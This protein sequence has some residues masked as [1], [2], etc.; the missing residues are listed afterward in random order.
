MS[1]TSFNDRPHFLQQPSNVGIKF[2]QWSSTKSLTMTRLSNNTNLKVSFKCSGFLYIIFFTLNNNYKEGRF[3]VLSQ[4]CSFHYPYYF[5]QL[6]CLCWLW[7]SLSK[8]QEVQGLSIITPGKV[9]TAVSLFSF[10]LA[11][12]TGKINWV[13]NLLTWIHSKL[14]IHLDFGLFS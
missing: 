8:Q 9:A 4:T 10:F 1:T 6:M 3:V 14:N 11:W 7:K 5:P 12:D 2:S 13:S